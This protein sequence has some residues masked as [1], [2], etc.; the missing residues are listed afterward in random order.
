MEIVREGLEIHSKTNILIDKSLLTEKI[1]PDRRFQFKPPNLNIDFDK[2]Y[3]KP[4]KTYNEKGKEK[5]SRMFYLDATIDHPASKI[6]EQLNSFQLRQ[7]WEES[8]KTSE[9]IISFIDN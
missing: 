2:I 4:F 6:N 1:F 8:F 9:K 5:E 7:Q 3:T